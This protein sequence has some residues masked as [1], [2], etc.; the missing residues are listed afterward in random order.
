MPSQPR[1]DVSPLSI[2]IPAGFAGRIEVG[3]EPLGTPV[4][5]GGRRLHRRS[6]FQPRPA[7]SR[8]TM[9]RPGPNAGAWTSPSPLRLSSKGSATREVRRNGRCHRPRDRDRTLANF[10][11]RQRSSAGRGRGHVYLSADGERRI[12]AV[13]RATGGAP[14]ERTPSTAPTIVASPSRVAWSSSGRLS[15]PCMPSAEM[16]RR[17]RRSHS[18]QG[19]FRPRH[20]PR[21]G[22]SRRRRRD[23]TRAWSGRSPLVTRTSYRGR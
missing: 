17:S 19:Q 16:A 4:I 18:Q 8:R 10:V 14:L 20:Q 3:S 11:Q 1:T 15:G 9:S 13:D 6:R 22:P 23:S 21:Y 12:V 2:Q 7:S 5:A